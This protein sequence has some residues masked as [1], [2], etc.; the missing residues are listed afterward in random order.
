MDDVEHDVTRQRC[1]GD[2]MNVADEAVDLGV[3][4]LADGH[5]PAADA[6]HFAPVEGHVF[7]VSPARISVNGPRRL[8][9]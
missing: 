8:R 7:C 4:H 1:F 5:R 2:R 6:I 9:A 3:A